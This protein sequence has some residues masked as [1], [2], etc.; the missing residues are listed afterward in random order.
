MAKQPEENE[1][2][3]NVGSIGEYIAGLLHSGELEQLGTPS[4][5]DPTPFKVDPATVN[6]VLDKTNQ[7]A[8]VIF[9]CPEPLMTAKATIIP[10]N[11][12]PL[13]GVCLAQVGNFVRGSGTR[14]EPGFKAPRVDAV[15]VLKLDDQH[16]IVMVMGLFKRNI[17]KP[18][19][20]LTAF[21]AA[22]R[23]TAP[24]V[25][26]QANPPAIKPTKATPAE[27]AINVP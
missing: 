7:E 3:S 25:T 16:E 1:S 19:E 18:Q 14:G 27:D 10:E 11:A 2:E 13:R 24:V 4:T 8:L 9:G 12:F 17:Q 5:A 20:A 15:R 21:G 23:T 6:L 22:R 26:G